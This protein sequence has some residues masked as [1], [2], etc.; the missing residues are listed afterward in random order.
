VLLTCL[1]ATRLFAPGVG[2]AAGAILAICLQYV[3]LSRM[4]LTDMHLSFFITLLLACFIIGI[5]HPERARR[6]LW[7]LGAWTASALAVLTKGP[8]GLVL[9]G[10]IALAYLVL[11]GSTLQKL[12]SIPWLSGALLFCAISLPWYIAVNRQSGG[13]FFQTFIIKHNI[14]RFAGEVAAGGQHVEPFYY[15]IPVLLLGML[16]FSLFAVQ[17]VGAPVVDMLRRM[18][19][20]PITDRRLFPLLWALGVTGFFSISR[21]KLPTYVTPA[22]PAL[23]IL[24]AA[25][26]HGLVL[27][28]RESGR[29]PKALLLPVAATAVLLGAGGVFVI[30]GAGK[31][32]PFPLD[33][34][35]L[36]TG[37]ALAAGPL[38][39]LALLL[40]RRFGAALLS[41]VAGMAAFALVLSL[42]VLP[43]VASERQEPQRELVTKA[44]DY[45]GNSGTLAAYRYRKTAMTFYSHKTVTYLEAQDLASG[46]LE[47]LERPAA[48]LT[49]K[50]YLDE[51]LE[52]APEV[53]SIS[54]RGDLTLVLLP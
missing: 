28:A 27:R 6:R 18:R 44:C 35:Q 13:E 29:L 25:Y 36:W 53:H 21:A 23:A 24:L 3:A 4:A 40:R 50:S 41:A 52:S 42:G 47:R 26:L 7:L 37:L 10:A 30:F 54:S 32:A 5:E 19:G 45:L 17:A 33:G 20:G 12:K 34:L 38:A 48:V 8:V 22:Y 51:L 9:P 15:Y 2:L 43:L 46:G 11:A 49:R 14:Q 16:P 31:L 1:A 39:G